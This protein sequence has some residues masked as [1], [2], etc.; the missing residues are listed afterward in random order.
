[1]ADDKLGEGVIVNL[2]P[3]GLR[4]ITASPLHLELE[5]PLCMSFHLG[6]NGFVERQKMSLLRMSGYGNRFEYSTKFLDASKEHLRMLENY[7]NFYRD[8][9]P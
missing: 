1:M 3:G 9:A 2:G 4:F 8:W 7:F 5:D 6:G